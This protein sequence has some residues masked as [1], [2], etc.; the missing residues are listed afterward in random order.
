[1][2]EPC[3]CKNELPELL[4]KGMRLICQDCLNNRGH[5][6]L[7]LNNKYNPKQNNVFIVNSETLSP[8]P[9][10]TVFHNR[11]ENNHIIPL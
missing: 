1:M 10:L 5:Y 2:Q 8:N 11:L 6:M 3:L 7:C 9:R 4:Q